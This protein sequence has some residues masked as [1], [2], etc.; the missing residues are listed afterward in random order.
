M[1][2]DSPWLQVKQRYAGRIRRF[3]ER[4]FVGSR[5]ISFR[6]INDWFVKKPND[7]PSYAHI[8]DAILAGKFNANGRSQILFL[9]IDNV[10]IR[11]EANVIAA[12][13]DFRFA[14]ADYQEA[15]HHERPLLEAE[16]LARFW[17][18]RVVCARWFRD[19]GYPLPPW[20]QLKN[21]PTTGKKPKLRKYFEEHF[22]E[23]VPSPSL[24]P[25]KTLQGKLLEWDSTLAPLDLGTLK[26]AID[27]YNASISGL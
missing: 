22:S 18:P 16:Y 10:L 9:W 2:S 3:E 20:L 23:G 21:A 4:H 17:I 19:E 13:P 24:E 7:F 8:A 6:R 12:R 14:V 1:T 25:R 5:W 27:E 11:Q 15:L 26:T